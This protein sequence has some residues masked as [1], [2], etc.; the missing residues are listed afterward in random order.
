MSLLR[1]SVGTQGCEVRS[2]RH[3]GES[4][5]RPGLRRIGR[6]HGAEPGWANAGLA[7]A[8][9]ADLSGPARRRPG[10]RFGGD[11]ARRTSRSSAGWCHRR[12]WPRTAGWARSARIGETKVA[13][14]GAD[15]AAGFGPALQLVTDQSAMLMD[16]VTVLL[17]RLGVAYI[18]IMNPVFRVRRDPTGELLE[19]RP[20]ADPHAPRDGIDESWIHVA[21]SPSVDAK[22][23]GR[24][25]RPAAQ[26]AR[27]RAP[28]G[29]R[30][31]GTERHPGR[32]GQRAGRRPRR[33]LPR[34]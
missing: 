29:R 2:D 11:G 7:R 15:D 13:V 24:G 9:L 25:G 5:Q 16:S 30:L 19:M 21:L 33:A 18:A 4:G 32:P 22:T 8:Y 23:R 31:G 27:R 3:D 6:H 17:H 12:C 28:G 14:Y 34:L 1:A 10:S 26:R 20:A